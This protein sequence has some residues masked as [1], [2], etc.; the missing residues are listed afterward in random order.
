M[1]YYNY[2]SLTQATT[3]L[4]LALGR[5]SLATGVF[6]SNINIADGSLLNFGREWKEIG[7]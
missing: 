4:T 3:A 7:K 1:T 5:G 2:N 6:K